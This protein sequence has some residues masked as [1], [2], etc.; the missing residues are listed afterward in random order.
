MENNNIIWH[1]IN[2][3]LKKEVCYSLNEK[4]HSFDIKKQINKTCKE[5]Q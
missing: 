1:V 4:I 3:F 2:T 5:E